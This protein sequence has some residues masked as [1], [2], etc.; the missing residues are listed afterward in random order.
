MMKMFEVVSLNGSWVTV[1][2]S[3]ADVLNGLSKLGYSEAELESL[4]VTELSVETV[5]LA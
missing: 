3:V 1:G 5:S 2:D 4:V